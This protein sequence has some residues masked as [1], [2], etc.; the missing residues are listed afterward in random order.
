MDGSA[1][2]RAA[3]LSYFH[4]IFTL[5]SAIGDIAYHKKAVIYGLLSSASAETMLTIVADPRHLGTGIGITSEL[6]SWGSAMMHHPHVYMV[7]PG[8]GLAKDGNRWVS[9]RPK[10]CP[11]VPVHSKL[12]R[13]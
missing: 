10:F 12:F 6:H 7:V 2:G 8:G 1:R 3:P 13:R 5:P 4:V 11:P 9:Y